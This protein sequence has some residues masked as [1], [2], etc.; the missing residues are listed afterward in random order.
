MNYFGEN[1]R[2]YY[3]IMHSINYM[4]ILFNWFTFENLRGFRRVTALTHS[5]L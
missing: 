4:I 1:D 2:Q 5:F 3:Y